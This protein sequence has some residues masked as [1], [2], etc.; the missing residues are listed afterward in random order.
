MVAG[1]KGNTLG[2]HMRCM[3]AGEVGAAQL[4]GMA[5]PHPFIQLCVCPP[6]FTRC[7]YTPVLVL[8]AFAHAVP[9]WLHIPLQLVSLAAMVSPGQ[10]ACASVLRDEVR[11]VQ[12]P[13]LA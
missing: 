3:P 7:S 10:A 4:S 5:Q 2:C 6:L 12:V 9:L 8:L 1:N 11:A 13:A